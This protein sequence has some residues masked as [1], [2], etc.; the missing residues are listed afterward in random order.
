MRCRFGKPEALR[1]RRDFLR[2]QNHG[3][4]F[5]RTH[6]VL[7]VAPGEEGRARVGYT[8]SRKVGN[9]VVRNRVRRRL[10][11]I[12]RTH[13]EL[14]SQGIDHVIVAYNNATTADFGTLE[15]ELTCLLQRVRAWALAA[16]SSS[17]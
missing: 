9:A 16:Q 5:Q 1:T 17:R 8:V 3:T 6:M 10:K 13:P 2:V 12:I 4:R 11:E 14:L 7:L 15:E